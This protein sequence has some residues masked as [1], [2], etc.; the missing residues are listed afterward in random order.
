MAD[1]GLQIREGGEG[2]PDPEIR[3]SGL[4]KKLFRASV[5]SENKGVPGHSS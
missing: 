1:P 2:H 3:G 4:K 5:W